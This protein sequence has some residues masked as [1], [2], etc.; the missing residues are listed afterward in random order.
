MKTLV[1]YFSQT[2]NTKRVAK[3][4]FEEL[5]GEKEIKELPEIEDAS[6]YD[7]LF[8]GFPIHGYGPAK[9]GADFL[10]NRCQGRPVALF[11]THAA[12]EYSEPLK[13]W[14]Q[15]C[16][17]AASGT[18]LKGMFNCQGELSE[19]I[20]EHMLKSGDPNLETWAKGPP[21]TIGQPDKSRLEKARAFV[22]EM[23]S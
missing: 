5:P 7:L 20:A 2:G 16:K 17:D 9:P 23:T 14:L 1:A 15:N 4:I 13:E 19:S 12:P 22:H 6:G 21:S 11:V 10:A 18:Q 3:A 8:V